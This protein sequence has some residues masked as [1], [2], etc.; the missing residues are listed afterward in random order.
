VSESRFATGLEITARATGLFLAA[1]YGTG[2]LIVAIHHAQYGIA[3]FD[4]LKPKIFS[5]GAVFFVLMAAPVMLAFRAFNI[6]GLRPK[7]PAFPLTCKPENVTLLKI[8]VGLSLLPAMLGLSNLFVFFFE[9]FDDWKPWGITSLL[10]VM[11]GFVVIGIFETKHFDKHPSL[12]A[13]SDF[14]LAILLVVVMYRFQDHHHMEFILWS[15]G[16][17]IGAILLSKVLRVEEIKQ[18]EWERQ[19]SLIAIVLLTYSTAIYG[20]I[21]PSF[22]GGAPTSVVLYFSGT[23]PISNSDSANVLLLEETDHGYYVL[24]NAQEPTAYFLRREL[25]SAMH[26]EKQGKQ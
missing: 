10:I 12:F 19:V 15:Y 23:T 6:F 14:V 8:V 20:K 13:V 18:F 2:F 4:P 7:N 26:F 1:V 3:Q 11:V 25:V 16:V 9:T 24:K 21:K 22:G 17:G 5:T